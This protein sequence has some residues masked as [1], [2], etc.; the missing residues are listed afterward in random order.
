[1]IN[2]Y[3][4]R[5]IYSV[6][7]ISIRRNIIRESGVTLTQTEAII[8]YLYMMLDIMFFST[9]TMQ[10]QKVVSLFKNAQMHDTFSSGSFVTACMAFSRRLER[11]AQKVISEQRV[12]AKSG[13]VHQKRSD[14]PQTV[15]GKWKEPNSAVHF[16]R[17][18]E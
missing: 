6:V 8:G 4:D 11:I 18:N 12:S 14:F 3:A 17:K 13:S 5:F 2:R 15:S 16:C 10:D 1:M 7:S 9:S